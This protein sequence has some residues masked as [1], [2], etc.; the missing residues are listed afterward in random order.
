MFN[1]DTLFEAELRKLID[2]N[3]ARLSAEVSSGHGVN[4]FAHYKYKTGVIA[5]LREAIGLFD[6]VK[7]EILKR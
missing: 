7:S 1:L 3:I 5:G 2:E 6:E 4:D